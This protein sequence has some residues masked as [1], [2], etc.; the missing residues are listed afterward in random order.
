MSPPVW[1]DRFKDNYYKGIIL[2][3]EKIID[4]CDDPEMLRKI[5]TTLRHGLGGNAINKS[6]ELYE[7][8]K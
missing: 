2:E 1:S 4:E 5:G 8:K 7:T 3:L 6:N